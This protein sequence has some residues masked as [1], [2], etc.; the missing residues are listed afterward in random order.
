MHWFQEFGENEKALT[1]IKEPSDLKKKL[2][3]EFQDV[4]YK[5]FA[6]GFECR[7]PPYIA[8]LNIGGPTTNAKDPK[9]KVKSKTF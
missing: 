3:Q 7:R 6:G 8:V 5:D 9:D 4:Y 1:A 2:A